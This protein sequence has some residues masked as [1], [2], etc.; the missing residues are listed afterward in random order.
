[1]Q[2]NDRLKISNGKSAYI[3]RNNHKTSAQ[4]DNEGIPV[5]KSLSKMNQVIPLLLGPK[6]LSSNG[7]QMLYLIYLKFCFLVSSIF[8]N[9]KK[10]HIL[11]CHNNTPVRVILS[12]IAK[13]R[14]EGGRAG[15]GG[16]A[17]HA[18]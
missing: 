10:W 7:L 12:I 8:Y 2:G 5:I 6:T 18:L 3:T 11:L 16:G 15:G 13:E 17:I 9:V 4:Q 14:R 1:M